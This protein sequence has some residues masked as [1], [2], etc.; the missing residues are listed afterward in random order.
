MTQG[1]T[2]SNVVSEVWR[3]GR[4]VSRTDKWAREELGTIVAAN[5]A[6]KVR[7]DSG[8]TSYYRRNMPAN[9]QLTAEPD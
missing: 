1:N 7:W 6:I 5:G 3:I 4:R 2:K 9:L 8:R